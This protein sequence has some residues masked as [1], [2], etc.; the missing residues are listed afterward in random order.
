MKRS[1]CA[2]ARIALRWVRFYTRGLDDGSRTSRRDEIAS[3]L[4][5]HAHHD[6]VYSVRQAR[7]TAA[8]LARLAAGIPS[9]LSWRRQQRRALPALLANGPPALAITKAWRATSI[10]I[11]IQGLYF[12]AVGFV[13]LFDLLGAR[14]GEEDGFGYGLFL[15]A[16]GLAALI[17]LAVRRRRPLTSMSLLCLSTFSLTMVTVWSPW[18][19]VGLLEIVLI[20]GTTPWAQVQGAGWSSHEALRRMREASANDEER[21][22]VS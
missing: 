17:G 20:V 8:I 2:G 10:L 19:L 5:E 21:S 18:T 4:W 7:T 3:D 16:H 13:I 1:T 6:A 12:A 11:L 15:I 14:G 9:D 22:S